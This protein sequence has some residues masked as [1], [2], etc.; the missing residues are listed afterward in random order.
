MEHTEKV[1]YI[2]PRFLF[3]ALSTMKF[4]LKSGYISNMKVSDVKRIAASIPAMEEQTR[5]GTILEN[6]FTGT[7]M[8]TQIA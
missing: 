4:T 2:T 8:R 5:L 6:Q 3:Y 1:E 7:K